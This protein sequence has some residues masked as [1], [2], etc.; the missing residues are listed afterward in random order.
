MKKERG[1]LFKAKTVNAILGDI[2]TK[3]RRCAGL[4]VVNKNPNLYK[5][6][7]MDHNGFL[8]NLVGGGGHVLCHPAK[9]QAGDQLWVRETFCPV[10]RPMND[11]REYKPNGVKY[12]ATYTGTGYDGCWKPSIFMPRWASRIQLEITGVRVERV[13]EITHDG[14]RSEGCIPSHI[15][16]GELHAWKRDYWIPLWE[17]CNGKLKKTKKY[18]KLDLSW[19]ANPW[20]WCYEF[21]RIKQ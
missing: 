13:Q 12:R 19:S 8:F 9:G 21:R 6:A 7:G 5:F 11:G 10:S 20:C 18:G 4:E 14:M 17:S 1:I 15:C 2:K 16:G 3:T